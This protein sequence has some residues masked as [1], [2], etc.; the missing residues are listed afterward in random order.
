MCCHRHELAHEASQKKQLASQTSCVRQRL[1]PKVT[2][3]SSLATE[4]TVRIRKALC[5]KEDQPL[6]SHSVSVRRA[7][8][9][10]PPP[11]SVPLRTRLGI[12]VW[13]VRCEDKSVGSCGNVHS[14]S[15]ELR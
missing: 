13:P 11:A 8:V 14:H 7:C 15:K 5:V 2:P 12:Q 1:F 10:T 3:S 6:S 9:A 4:L